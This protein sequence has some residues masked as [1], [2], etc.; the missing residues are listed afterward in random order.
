MKQNN[1]EQLEIVWSDESLE[2][3]G[4]NP[5]PVGEWDV[6][7]RLTLADLCVDV[8]S[9]IWMDENPIDTSIGTFNV[10]EEID[11]D[12]WYHYQRTELVICLDGGLELHGWEIGLSCRTGMAFM[13]PVEWDDYSRESKIALAEWPY[14]IDLTA[15]VQELN[16]V[17]WS[18]RPKSLVLQGESWDCSYWE[19][20]GVGEVVFGQW[21]EGVGWSGS[22]TVSRQL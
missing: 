17:D 16:E 5:E 4:G 15:L 13:P 11:T 14:T 19:N 8:A 1:E 6:S 21:L 10:R 3:T 18:E 22:L 7:E 20:D 9:P 2:P 12:I